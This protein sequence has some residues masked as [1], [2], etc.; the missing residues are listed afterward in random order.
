MKT[1]LQIIQSATGEMGL[2]VPNYVAGNTTSDTVQM[3]ALLNGLG[4]DLMREFDWQALVKVYSWASTGTETYS[5]PSDYDRQLDRTHYDSS[6]K[7]EM[8][9]PESPQQWAFLTNSYISTGPRARY[10]IF[11]NKIHIWPATISGDTLTFEYV[12]NA[13]ATDS[14][15]TAKSSFTVDTDTSIFPD[16]LMITGLKLRYFSVKGFNTQEFQAEFMRYLSVA[17]SDD[18][19]SPVLSFA[20]KMSSVLIGYENIPDTNYGI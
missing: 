5:L 9:G 2:S 3:L 1:M 8:L 18:Q 20:P 19:G 17:K 12:S 6:K 10:R 11:G 15:G 7:W 13:W 4:D 14:G 16:R